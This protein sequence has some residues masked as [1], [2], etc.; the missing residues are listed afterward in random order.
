M[1]L[2]GIGTE[3]NK[4]EAVVA[5]T[6][7]AEQGHCKSQAQLGMSYELGDGVEEDWKKAMFWYSRAAEQGDMEAASMFQDMLRQ[8]GS[9][10]S[11][12]NTPGLPRAIRKKLWGLDA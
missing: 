6:L 5:F 3:A 4:K 8:G 11:G 1:L 7:A 9:Y 12:G 2:G 10:G